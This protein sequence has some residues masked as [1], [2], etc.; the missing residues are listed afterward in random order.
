ML[1][2]M[3]KKKTAE[4]QGDRHR[5]AMVSFRPPADLR[6]Q[7][8]AIATTERRSVAQVVQILVEEAIEARAKK[9]KGGA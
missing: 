5:H 6:E 1:D 8:V 4:E 3:S 7:I 2:T 9:K